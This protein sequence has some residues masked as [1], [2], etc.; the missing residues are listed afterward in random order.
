MRKSGRARRGNHAK[1]RHRSSHFIVV[2]FDDTGL[3]SEVPAYLYRAAQRMHTN[4]LQHNAKIWQHHEASRRHKSSVSSALLSWR[5]R[6]LSEL[7]MSSMNSRWP[8]RRFYEWLDIDARRESTRLTDAERRRKGGG[9]R[10]GGHRRQLDEPPANN[11]NN[12][13]SN[14]DNDSERR[15]FRAEHRRRRR[16]HREERQR[17]ARRENLARE[18]TRIAHRLQI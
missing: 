12:R 17:A 5:S 7:L 6:S 4:W 2:H 13:Q 3:L 8:A 16:L 18:Q 10:S 1:R 15:V 14:G 9:S 11:N